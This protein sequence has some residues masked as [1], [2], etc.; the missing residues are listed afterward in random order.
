M[1]M[2]L[3]VSLSLWIPHIIYFW[4]TLASLVISPFVFNPHQ[5]VL[6][7]FIYDYQ[8]YLGWLSKG[9]ARRYYEHSWIAFCRQIRTQVTGNKKKARMK[10]TIRDNKPIVAVPR[11]HLSSIF[12]A[13]IIMP[14]LQ[15]VL[16]LFCYIFYK[17]REQVDVYGA[18]I[19]RV[20][21]SLGPWG[22]LGRILGIALGPI[23]FNAIF[24]IILQIISVLI[25]LSG[26]ETKRIGFYMAALAHG[27][28]ILGYV[29]FYEVFW[30]LEKF[31][32]QSTLLG[33]LG[34]F[35]VQRFIFKTF[36]SIFLTRELHHDATNRTWWSGH[37]KS[38]KVSN[39]LII[40]NFFIY[41]FFL[42]KK[43]GGLA[44]REYICKIV[45]MSVFTTDFILGH[46]ILIVLF[47][48]TLIPYID[49]IHSLILFWLRPSKQIRPA[50]L[51]TKERKRRKQVAM[52]Y[53]PIFIFMLLWFAALIILPPRL[54]P[55]LSDKYHNLIKYL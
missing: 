30:A 18:L 46:I 44:A 3:F 26:L 36:V 48:F 55:R 38:S 9:N 54:I 29:F 19:N 1:F 10:S 37:W 41:T 45:E 23:V 51:P 40:W 32:I 11:P 34:I 4:I 24:L 22:S 47:P 8:E 49:R 21:T 43:V 5:F 16:C 12:F 27:L 2:L 20:N 50:V 31:E 7:D 25:A 39:P 33:L 35:S 42:Q 15:S 17:S 52:T 6:M 13:E 28:A 14:L 53:G